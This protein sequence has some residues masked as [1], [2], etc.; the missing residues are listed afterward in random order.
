MMARAIKYHLKTLKM[1]RIIRL[2]WKP[3]TPESISNKEMKDYVENLIR[4]VYR[5]TAPDVP[6]VQAI[7]RGNVILLRLPML[8]NI[9]KNIL[10]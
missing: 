2:R 7:G 1:G 8:T 6:I 4:S 10:L 5:D 9:C 3:D